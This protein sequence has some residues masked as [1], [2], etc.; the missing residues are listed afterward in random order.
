VTPRLDPDAGW[1][2]CADL[3]DSEPCCLSCGDDVSE[4]HSDGIVMRLN[5]KNIWLCCRHIDAAKKAGATWT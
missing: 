5:D 2:T 3:D 1:Y 4:G